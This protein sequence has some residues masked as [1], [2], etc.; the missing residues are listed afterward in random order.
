MSLH[1]KPFNRR[2]ANRG[3]GLVEVL[4]AILVMAVGVLGIAALQATTLRNSLGALER[5]QAVVQTYAIL[6][7]MRA[8]AAVARIGGYNLN[9][10]TC[11]APTA[12]SLAANDL[13]AWILALHD[14]V[15][16]SACG[17]IKCGTQDCTITVQWDASRGTASGDEEKQALKTHSITTETRL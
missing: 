16:A 12:G 17:Q 8:N 4:V 11:E 13:R 1:R 10:M 9:A 6:D 15:G 3:V 14:N 5:S 2:A 7:A